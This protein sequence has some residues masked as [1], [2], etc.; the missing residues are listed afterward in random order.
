MAATYGLLATKW[1]DSPVL[2]VLLIATFFLVVQ[3]YGFVSMPQMPTFVMVDT[4]SE[5]NW[6]RVEVPN[7]SLTRVHHS[8]LLHNKIWIV[9]F[10]EMWHVGLSQRTQQEVCPGAY[11]PIES[12]VT[13][14]ATVESAASEL[15]GRVRRNRRVAPLLPLGRPFLLEDGQDREVI[16]AFGMAIQGVFRQRSTRWFPR[17]MKP[18][19]L[20]QETK[21]VT[22]NAS[23]LARNEEFCTADRAKWLAR[24]VSYAV[25]RFKLKGFIP[26]SNPM[27]DARYDEAICCREEI[28]ETEDLTQC[29]LECDRSGLYNILS[30]F[31]Q[32]R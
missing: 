11:G 3:K 22:K 19:P 20:I 6:T 12:H 17:V 10:D 25:R 14:G 24:A 30:T 13:S 9:P 1:R 4:F 32:G 2:P 8:G 29:G 18:V 5:S 28:D 26:K 7:L 23:K 15:A 16:Y 27:D 21:I 31:P